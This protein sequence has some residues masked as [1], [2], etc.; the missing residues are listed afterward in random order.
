MSIVAAIKS[1]LLPVLISGISNG[2][3]ASS[4]EVQANFFDKFLNV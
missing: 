3:I 2:N 1:I 4:A